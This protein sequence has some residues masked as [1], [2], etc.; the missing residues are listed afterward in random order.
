MYL[1][2]LLLSNLQ[3]GLDTPFHPLD[4]NLAR[5][6]LSQSEEVAPRILD[7]YYPFASDQEVLDFFWRPSIL[8]TLHRNVVK[9]TTSV[10]NDGFK[11]TINV[12][13]YKPEEVTVRMVGY[14]VVIEAKHEDKEDK[15][16]GVITRQFV[17]RYLLP[18]SAEIDQIKST[19]SSDGIL[20]ITVPL[21]PEEKKVI[22]IEQTGQPALPSSG[23]NEARPSE[24][25]AAVV[26]EKKVENNEVTREE[27]TATHGQD[28]GPK[29]EK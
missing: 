22:Q 8:D 24:T 27:V 15:E 21:K 9:S 12:Q 23:A 14:W 25:G 5:P 18:N 2:P 13:Q 26:V 6:S 10:D 20:T 17:R 11:I 28:E 7:P 1:L 29:P 19:I 4:S 3:L 16:H